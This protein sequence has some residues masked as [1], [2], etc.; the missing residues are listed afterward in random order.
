MLM[1]LLLRTT[2]QDI[3]REFCR[4]TSMYPEGDEYRLLRLKKDG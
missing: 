3:L 2:L 4:L 1:K